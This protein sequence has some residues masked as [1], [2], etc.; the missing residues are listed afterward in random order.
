MSAAIDPYAF[1]REAYLQQREYLIHDGNPP[2]EDYDALFDE[3]DDSSL[4]ID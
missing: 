3:L 2:T 4:S 1:T